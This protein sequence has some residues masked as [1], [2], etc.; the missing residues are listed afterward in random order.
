[1]GGK[2]FHAPCS[3]HFPCQPKKILDI[4]CG[5]GIFTTQLARRFPSAQVVGV[6][7]L[8]VPAA[9]G[10]PGNVKF[11]LG[12][13]AD[14][15][16]GGEIEAGSFDYVFERLTM[17]S[18]V[19]WEAHLRDVVARLLAPGGFVEVQEYDSMARAGEAGCLGE[20]RG[21]EL[22]ARWEWFRLWIEDT[23]DI[24]LDLRVGLHMDELLSA[25]GLETAGH[26]VYDIPNA[27]PPL[28]QGTS[29]EYLWKTV[30][31]MYWGVVERSS[32]PRR[33]PDGLRVMRKNYEETFV[34]NIEHLVVRLHVLVGYKPS[35]KNTQ[36]KVP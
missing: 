20:A 11:L 36:H 33:T 28:L 2:V 35:V 12:S 24:G 32:G 1:M 27:G 6:D 31:D 26:D 14:L 16:A 7:L 19:D 21:T 3:A 13:A 34:A 15:L 8:A 25:A 22:G 29:N 4:G 9:A 23:R 30:V 17:L 10:R 5:T 18:I